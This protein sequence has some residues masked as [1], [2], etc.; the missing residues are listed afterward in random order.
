MPLIKGFRGFRYDEK[1]VGNLDDV[2]TP[3]YDVINAEQRAGLMARSPHNMVHLLLPDGDGDAKYQSATDSLNAWIAEGV[4]AQDVEDSFYLLEQTFAGVEGQEYVRRGFFAVGQLPE[5]GERSY[6]GHERTFDAKVG[7]RLKLTEATEAN[8]G[9][10]F[11]SYTDPNGVLKD[12]LATMDQRPADATA[13]TIDGVAQRLWRVPQDDRVTDFFRDKTLYID[14]GHH[15]FRTA[16]LYR[17]A[18]RKKENPDGPRP[19]DFVLLG[20]VAFDDPGL[21]IWP[22]HRL[23]AMPDDFD[24]AAFL[25]AL[26]QWFDVE[27]VESDLQD[28]VEAAEGC[29][30]GVAAPAHAARC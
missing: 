1:V 27:A 14:D 26:A 16:C 12:F 18:M 17:E 23:A 3:P 20:F 2:V 21:L 8:L 28:R 13:H 25:G 10:V 5:E 24:E 7:D 11:I 19:Y 6:L 9:A 22:T 29:A 30:I 15:R 4:M